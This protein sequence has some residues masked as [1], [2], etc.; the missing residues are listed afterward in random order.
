M[1]VILL[2]L[3]LLS[4]TRPSIVRGRMI[5]GPARHPSFYPSPRAVGRDSLSATT[6]T[7]VVVTRARTTF[8]KLVNALFPIPFLSHASEPRFPADR[9]ATADDTRVH[10]SHISPQFKACSLGRFPFRRRL[11]PSR[12][13]YELRLTRGILKNIRFSQQQQQQQHVLVIAWPRIPSRKSA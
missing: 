12:D 1:I 2:I 8:E 13:Q 10:F 4:Y 5:P 3:L 11:R 7:A 6:A 9:I